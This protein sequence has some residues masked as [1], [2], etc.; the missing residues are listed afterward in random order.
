MNA[1][2]EM[3][4]VRDYL[5]HQRKLIDNDPHLAD[6]RGKLTFRIEGW[7]ARHHSIRIVVR[8]EDVP[9]TP[10]NSCGTR[11]VWVNS[12]SV[13]WKWELAKALN[14]LCWRIREGKNS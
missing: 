11:F 5:R 12:W 8:N 7:D 13:S 6:I 3:K 1:K 10:Y 2:V 4:Q 9:R 14:E